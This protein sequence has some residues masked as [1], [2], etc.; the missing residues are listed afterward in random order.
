MR[1]MAERQHGV[2]SRAQARGLGASE[3]VLRSCVASPDWALL[4]TQVF[5]L[6][7]A[8]RTFRQRSMAAVLDAG[9]AAAASHG[10]ALALWGL[11]G[12]RP[13]T[14]DVS[15]RRG[16][17]TRLSTMA[18]VH[19]PRLWPPGHVT[20]VH[21]I[22]V[23]TMARTVFD[24]AGVLH[25]GRTERAL[26]NA[27]ARHLTSLPALRAVTGEMVGHGRAGSALMRRLLADREGSYVAPESGL[28]ARFASILAAAGL[29]VPVRQL[30][31]GGERWAGRVDHVDQE[32]NLVIE[33][34]SDLH[35][36]TLT[37][38]AA[39]RR[40]DQ[41]LRKAGYR[42]VRVTEQ[43]IWYR[44]HEVVEALKAS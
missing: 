42:V 17:T 37:D 16:G 5:R 8:P 12:P 33:I 35:H 11:P 30:D 24:L 27:L 18:R 21:G 9:A 31:V 39:D 38:R 32:R 44:P 19:T 43:Q 25:P 13:V 28:E 15:R 22:P 4:T 3:D 36:T 14:L 20:T 6:V 29:P 23:T 7:G 2:V 34:D 41:A 1:E 40:R 10:T 26:D